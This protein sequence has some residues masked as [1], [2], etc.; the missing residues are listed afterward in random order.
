[1]PGE[2][3]RDELEAVRK[4]RGVQE[5]QLRA[6]VGPQLRR[7]CQIGADTPH[8][9]ARRVLADFLHRAADDLPAELQLAANV[10]FAVDDR[11]VQRFLRQR[12]EA[13]A[14]L[15]NCD[16][17]T[18]QR[19]CDEA[20]TLIVER[21]QEYDLP[22][23]LQEPDQSDA[24]DAGSWYVARLSAVLLLN[25]ARPEAIE[26]R[27][28]VAATDGLS[29]LGVALGVPRHPQ[30]RR[31][32]LE[33]DMEILYGARLDAVQRPGENMFVSVLTLPRPLGYGE[34]HTYVRAVRIPPGQ[35]MV[36]RYVHVPVRRCDLFE[37]RVKFRPE[38]LPRAVW[39]VS[40]LPELV[41]VDQQP[42]KLRIEPDPLGEV[43]AR[44][45]ELQ[46][47]FGYG[48]AWLP[49]GGGHE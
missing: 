8:G 26:E 42:G 24:F 9:T 49:A 3:L 40:R 36:P 5:P 29:Q 27:T 15:W 22:A 18:V 47:G 17:R 10:M 7:L 44:F 30:E 39:L 37:L 28:L 21:L 46:L 25:R 43:F 35:L 14:A 20:L 34:R 32:Q 6:R 31:P 19:R 41:F 13:L 38:A 48:I 2:T 23:L 11:Y 1:M 45:S 33:V 4:G 12:Y 16:F